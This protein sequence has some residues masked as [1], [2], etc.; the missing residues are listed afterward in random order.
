[1]YA[2]NRCTCVGPCALLQPSNAQTPWPAIPSGVRRHLWPTDCLG[3]AAWAEQ[4]IQ[5]PVSRHCYALEHCMAARAPEGRHDKMVRCRGCPSGWSW[6]PGTWLARCAWLPGE[7]RGP[8]PAPPGRTCRSTSPSCWTPSRCAACMSAACAFGTT[9]I[10][11]SRLVP[12]PPPTLGG[13]EQ[14]ERARFQ[15]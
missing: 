12:G 15:H 13:E 6:G 8:R 14:A 1:M 7:T 5:G 3:A 10:S 9:C 11:W 4:H 2:L